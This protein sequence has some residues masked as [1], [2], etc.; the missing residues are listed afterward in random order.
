LLAGGTG[1]AALAV[2]LAILA[3]YGL[4]QIYEEA[5]AIAEIWDKCP[6]ERD[7]RIGRLI[8]QVVGALLGGKAMSK[9]GAGGAGEGGG[10]PTCKSGESCFVA[11]TLVKT[12]SGEKRIEE[13]RTGDVV[14]SFDPEHRDAAGAQT[15]RQD[16]TRTFVRIAPVVLDIH[17]GTETITAT[18]EHPFWVIGAGWTAAGELR[19]GSALLTK[20][21]VVVHVDYVECRQGAF[22][23]YNFEVSNAHTYY[24]SAMGVLV[25][26]QC[27][28][29]GGRGPGEAPPFSRSEYPRLSPGE[30]EAA[31]ARE[32]ICQYC[33]KNPSTQVDHI[34]SLK[35]DWTDGGWK[36]TRAARGARVNDPSNS[37]GAC[38][39]CN[40]SKG[41]KPIG[42]GP[43][44]WWPPGW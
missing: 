17:V 43:G 24:V 31:L 44:Q 7:Y 11:G 19:R 36:D 28:G 39:S 42:Q 40:G 13:V 30:R 2:A 16:V 5:K 34:E 33:G 27:G 15:E 26:N 23:V 35:Q 8:G 29:S 41:A 14:L 18:P 10:C 32:P 3:A 21:G 37:A 1:G 6:D 38:Q 22:Q 4:Y 25:H 20:D 12:S 9:A